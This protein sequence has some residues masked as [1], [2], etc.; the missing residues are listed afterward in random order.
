MG[1]YAQNDNGDVLSRLS[2]LL[3]ELAEAPGDSCADADSKRFCRDASVWLQAVRGE[4]AQLLGHWASGV[5]SIKVAS[6]TA[7][8]LG[9]VC[10]HAPTLLRP[11]GQPR[12]QHEVRAE[13]TSASGAEAPPSGY[14]AQAESIRAD[15]ANFRAQLRAERAERARQAAEE[16]RRFVEGLRSEVRPAAPK[17]EREVREGAG[18][19]S[20]EQSHSGERPQSLA[21]TADGEPDPVGTNSTRG[22]AFRQVVAPGLLAQDEPDSSVVVGSLMPN[23]LTDVLPSSDLPQDGVAQHHTDHGSVAGAHR[24]SAN[25]TEP[26]QEQMHSISPRAPRASPFCRTDRW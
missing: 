16:R 3:G 4:V 20:L 24:C 10:T 26:R 17:P 14:I 23:S 19:L 9:R 7:E 2:E 22:C 1:H 11:V 18:G 12:V 6:Q 25:D 15:V 13:E 8:V 5:Q 21:A